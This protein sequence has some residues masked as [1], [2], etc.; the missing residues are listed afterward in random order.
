M[1]QSALYEMVFG[2]KYK[3]EQYKHEPHSFKEDCRITG[4]PYCS[5]CGL[6]ALNN[7]FTRWS[8]EKGCLSELH[9]SYEAQRKKA[10]T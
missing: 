8:I 7:P 3:K 10:T 1:K 4:K 5:K 2:E 9:P 6:I